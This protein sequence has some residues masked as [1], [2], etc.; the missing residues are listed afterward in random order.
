MQG[1]EWSNESAWSGTGK[2]KGKFTTKG[3]T[4]ATPDWWTAWE[5]FRARRRGGEEA[6]LPSPARPTEPR[7]ALPTLPRGGGGG[8]GKGG[9]WRKPG[10]ASFLKNHRM[11]LTHM[12]TAGAIELE[13]AESESDWA[14]DRALNVDWIAFK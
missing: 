8:Q 4:E 7:Q 5:A 6:W 12:A 11:M 13:Q 9:A 3:K 2:G 14:N 1:S 10:T